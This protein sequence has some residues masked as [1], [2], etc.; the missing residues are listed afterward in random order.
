MS[1]IDHS[2]LLS[3]LAEIKSGSI[4]PLYMSNEHIAAIEAIIISYM[5][6]AASDE[7]EQ[8]NL[9]LAELDIIFNTLFK[10]K[11]DMVH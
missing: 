8:I 4:E 7:S 9:V 6:V 10:V 2:K 5:S 11:N 1:K 3:K